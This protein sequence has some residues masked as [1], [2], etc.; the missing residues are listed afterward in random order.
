MAHLTPRLFVVVGGS[1]GH[2][3]LCLQPGASVKAPNGW[4]AGPVLVVSH[5]HRWACSHGLNVQSVKAE[6]LGLLEA[7]AWKS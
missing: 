7:K 4:T 1:A 3:R 5:P 2:G 6:D